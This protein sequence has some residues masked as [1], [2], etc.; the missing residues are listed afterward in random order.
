V[1]LFN[2]IYHQKRKAFCLSRSSLR[3]ILKSDKNWIK[4]IG[5]KDAYYRKF[6]D[7]IFR[8]KLFENVPYEKHG[9]KLMVL[10]IIHPE[11][12]AMF[13]FDIDAQ[14]SEALDFAK[15]DVTKNKADTKKEKIFKPCDKEEA[16]K[17][18]LDLP[19][20]SKD[21]FD[22]LKDQEQVIIEKVYGYKYRTKEW[23]SLMDNKRHLEVKALERAVL[24]NF[25]F[26]YLKMTEKDKISFI[27]EGFEK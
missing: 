19:K 26:E 21:A 27:S 24:D 4:T 2:A 11:L 16:F 20:N 25:A 1:S 13:N 17:V 3:D 23:R 12:L 5:L 18:T 6:L 14:L 22:L 10:K 8:S 15:R 7:H 9:H